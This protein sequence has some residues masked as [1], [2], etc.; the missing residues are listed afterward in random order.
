MQISCREHAERNAKNPSSCGA[1]GGSQRRATSNGCAVFTL[2]LTD[3]S[4]FQRRSKS[5]F[6]RT[7]IASSLGARRASER[8]ALIHVRVGVKMP[9]SGSQR[10]DGGSYGEEKPVVAFDRPWCWSR[11]ALAWCSTT[12]VGRP[13]PETREETRTPRPFPF[14]AGSPVLERNLVDVA[15]TAPL[16]ISW[17]GRRRSGSLQPAVGRRT[18][19]HTPLSEAQ[20]RCHSA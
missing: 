12:S 17:S 6:V 11:S 1:I 4:G 16:T 5:A 8:V 7:A 10:S 13:V 15:H 18:T 20:H 3:Y 2:L 14:S 9:H 19:H